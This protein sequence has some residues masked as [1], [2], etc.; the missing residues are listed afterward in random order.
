MGGGRP[1]GLIYREIV[2]LQKMSRAV[3]ATAAL[4]HLIQDLISSRNKWLTITE[5]SDRVSPLTRTA[6]HL[7]G[8]KKM[9]WINEV[10]FNKHPI[11]G[12]RFLTTVFHKFR[13]NSEPSERTLKIHRMN[14]ERAIIKRRQIIS[15]NRIRQILIFKY[16]TQREKKN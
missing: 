2:K 15:I 10:I 14:E 9:K 4:E 5:C 1:L 8:R 7:N 11:F 16:E 6:D 3:A 13:L 12:F